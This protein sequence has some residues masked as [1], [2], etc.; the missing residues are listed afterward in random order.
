MGT[1]QE[2]WN[3]NGIGYQEWEWNRIFEMRI[4]IYW[5][6]ERE[7]IRTGNGNLLGMERELIRNGNGIGDFEWEFIRNG[8]VT[9]H[10][11]F[12]IGMG[13]WNG[14]GQLKMGMKGH[15]QEWEQE[16]GIGNGR[17]RMGMETGNWELEWKTG[18]LVV[19]EE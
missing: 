6:W 13:D 12:G 4:G 5:E 16:T 3:G 14:N 9:G 10:R 17:L 11:R 18:E 2:I 8:M 19:K 7:F 1:D 15:E